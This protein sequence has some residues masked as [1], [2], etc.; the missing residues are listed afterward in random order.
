M[1][2]RVE[3]DGVVWLRVKD[4]GGWVGQDAD[5]GEVRGGEDGPECGARHSQRM[6][7]QIL[8]KKHEYYV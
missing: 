8:E 2:E 5:V 1:T 4:G 6:V 3:A 7:R